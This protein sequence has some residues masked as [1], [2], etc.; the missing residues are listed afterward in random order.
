MADTENGKLE[1]PCFL[2]VF[3]LFSNIFISNVDI[4]TINCSDMF[5]STVNSPM[6]HKTYF[7]KY[8]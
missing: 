6:W 3:G 5:K 2:F 8:K 4:L 7:K 1:Y